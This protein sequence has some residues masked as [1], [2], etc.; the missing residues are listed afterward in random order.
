M[1][2]IAENARKLSL[3]SIIVWK[4]NYTWT[5]IGKDNWSSL[6]EKP[7]RAQIMLQLLRK[8]NTMTKITVKIVSPIHI[9]SNRSFNN[10]QKRRHTL[11]QKK[12]MKFRFLNYSYKLYR[13]ISQ[14]YLSKKQ[15][16]NK[17]PPWGQVAIAQ[18]N[19]TA[20]ELKNV[21]EKLILMKT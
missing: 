19:L 2:K 6:I 12:Q 13:T 1:K 20:V 15:N 3:P 17:L 16:L 9:N 18:I 7:I 4:Q 5:S 21:V 10:N 8:L 11:N 14:L